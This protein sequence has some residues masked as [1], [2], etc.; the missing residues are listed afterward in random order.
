MSRDILL[1]LVD[2]DPEQPRQH[3]D[4]VKIGELAQSMLA[5]GLA[6]PILLR[7]NGERFVIVHGERRWRAAKMLEWETIPADVRELT[8]EESHWLSL[9]ENI[10]RADLTPIEEARAYAA[11]LSNGVTQTELGARI[12]K[13]QSYIAHKIQLLNLPPG[14]ADYLEMGLLGEGHVRQLLR[15][16]RVF[17]PDLMRDCGYREDANYHETITGEIPWLMMGCFILDDMRPYAWPPFWWRWLINWDVPEGAMTGDEVIKLVGAP[18]GNGAGG[19]SID[20]QLTAISHATRNWYAYQHANHG[21]LPQW[22]CAAMWFASFHAFSGR[23]VADLNEWIDNYSLLFKA[24]IAMGD[25]L[26]PLVK[27]TEHHDPGTLTILD[28]KP[29]NPNNYLAELMQ[30]QAIPLLADK[31]LVR[32]M[33][34]AVGGKNSQMKIPWP[35]AFEWGPFRPER[36]PA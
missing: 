2:P 34:E 28:D 11:Y 5:N 13:S 23:S 14:I 17:T 31:Q 4:P 36:I 30:C 19:I 15:L 29:K 18:N 25:V 10:Q 7:P 8:G 16:R 22:E 24:L 27:L 6:V 12:G 20:Y 3:F 26:Y 21:R 32:Q 35:S 33:Q 9:I 1:S